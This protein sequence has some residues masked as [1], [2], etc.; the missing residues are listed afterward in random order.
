[1]QKEDKSK[2]EMKPYGSGLMGRQVKRSKRNEIN[3]QPSKTMP[4]S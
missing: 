1:M 3:L 4:D 2:E